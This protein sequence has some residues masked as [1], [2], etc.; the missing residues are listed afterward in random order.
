MDVRYAENASAKCGFAALRTDGWTDTGFHR[1]ARTH[2]KTKLYVNNSP[3]A[4]EYGA[5]SLRKM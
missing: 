5:K 3:E 2:L 1:D 4:L